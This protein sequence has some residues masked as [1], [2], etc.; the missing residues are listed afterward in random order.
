[1]SFLARRVHRVGMSRSMANVLLFLITMAWGLSYVLLKIGAAALPPFEVLALRFTLASV[2]CITIFRH[3]LGRLTKRVLYYGFILGS[4][5]YLCSTAIIY[6][7]N[8]T[9]ASTA[10]FLTSSA[11]VIVPV[12]Q[13]IRKRRLPEKKIIFGTIGTTIGI[14]LLSL[15]GSLVLSAG[16]TLCIISA[17][18]YAAHIIMT[19]GMTRKEDAILLGIVQMVVMTAWGWIT[20][21]LYPSGHANRSQR[22][23]RY[24]SPCAHL[25]CLRLCYPAF[26]TKL[27]HTGKHCLDFLLRAC[28]WGN[29]RLSLFARGAFLSSNLRG[30][31]RSHQRS[32]NNGAPPNK[33][34]TTTMLLSPF[35]LNNYRFV[36]SF[37]NLVNKMTR[38]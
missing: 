7:M 27:H 17:F 30:T 31:S 37:F 19:D 8:T 4:V 5:M 20:T 12:A 25:R 2:V 24:F 11:I 13:A 1:M 35:L 3:R 14:A 10:S 34:I 15:K 33:K 38:K 22:M 26:C 23:A 6:G 28:F 16:A 18:L 21:L 32:S 29:L 36:V 9:E